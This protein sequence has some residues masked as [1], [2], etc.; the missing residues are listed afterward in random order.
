MGLALPGGL[1]EEPPLKSATT[2]NDE[3]G[4]EFDGEATDE[5]S[6]FGTAWEFEVPPSDARRLVA[7]I[8]HSKASGIKRLPFAK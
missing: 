2:G 4:K 5:S 8:A 3:T 1:F 7:N 6:G